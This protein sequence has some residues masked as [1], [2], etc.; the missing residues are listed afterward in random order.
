MNVSIGFLLKIIAFKAPPTEKATNFGQKAPN[1][2][3]WYLDNRLEFTRKILADV[4]FH[5]FVQNN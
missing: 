2:G 3:A 4:I 1:F 5:G